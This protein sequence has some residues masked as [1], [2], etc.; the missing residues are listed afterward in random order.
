M[1]DFNEQFKEF[2]KLQSEFFKPL[3]EANGLLADSFES[4]TRLGYSTSGD[5]V[6]YAIDQTQLMASAESP[7][8]LMSK[9]YEK[10]K[11]LGETITG[12]V[13]E[14]T[15]LS[16]EFFASLQ[17]VEVAPIFEAPAKATAK[18][19]KAAKTAAA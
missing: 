12:R 19:A 18:A 15:E 11:E 10:A 5:M 13:N 4:F 17:K 2:A 8:D 1:T 14:C 16:K 9:Q 6:D 3:R 7:T